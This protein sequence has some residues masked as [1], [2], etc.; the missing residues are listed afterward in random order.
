MHQLMAVRIA[1]PRTERSSMGLQPP[2]QAT[3]SLRL[4]HL[5]E[6]PPFDVIR[7]EVQNP[8]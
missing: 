2:R 5:V 8:L 7:H 6:L 3:I 4:N 1:E